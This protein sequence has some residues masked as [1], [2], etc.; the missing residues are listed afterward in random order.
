MATLNDPSL[1]REDTGLKDLNLDSSGNWEEAA[2]AVALEWMPENGRAVSCKTKFKIRPRTSSLLGT[3]LSHRPESA[4]ATSLRL[5]R[6]EGL[7]ASGD[8]SG[9]ALEFG[10]AKHGDD[11]NK[12]NS[13][14]TSTAAIGEWVIWLVCE[15]CGASKR[16]SR[17][18][19]DPAR[20]IYDGDEDNETAGMQPTADRS[21]TLP[22]PSS[23]CSAV[24]DEH[25]E[26]VAQVD[27]RMDWRRVALVNSPDLMASVAET[28]EE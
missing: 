9:L 11:D 14:R 12:A 6:L 2:A 3:S 20:Y 25:S 1:L 5:S 24:Y 21:L 7:H 17:T 23:K 22:T 13:Q 8:A 4:G 16:I 18:I 15:E 26:N 10:L 28:R 27:V 19:G